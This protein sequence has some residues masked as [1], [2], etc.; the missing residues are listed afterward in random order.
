M[1]FQYPQTNLVKD[2]SITGSHEEFWT[3]SQVSQWG[4]HWRYSSL[5]QDKDHLQPVL[6]TVM[7]ARTLGNKHQCKPR[8]IHYAQLL[9]WRFYNKEKLSDYHPNLILPLA[10]DCAAQI[11]EVESPK[12]LIAQDLAAS[13]Q[14]ENKNKSSE[15]GLHFAL[16]TSLDYNIRIH[17]P[18]DYICQFINANFTQDEMRLAEIIISDSFLIPCC[19]VHRPAAIAEGAAIMAAGM[20]DRPDS[21]IPRTSKALSFI[22]DMKCFYKQKQKH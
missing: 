22:Q 3:F 15:F 16:V 13:G 14:I 18:L 8:L 10:F 21:V 6:N 1:N 19:L 20:L 5:E 12:Q 4:T 11:L 17:H 2:L 9:I 7:K